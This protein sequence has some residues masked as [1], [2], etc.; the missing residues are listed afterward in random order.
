MRSRKEKRKFTKG[1][2]RKGKKGKKVKSETVVS[3]NS[4]IMEICVDS[5]NHSTTKCKAKGS[6]PSKDGWMNNK[7]K[8]NINSQNCSYSS[9]L[10]SQVF[11]SPQQTPFHSLVKTKIQNLNFD[12]C[13][14][15]GSCMSCTRWVECVDVMYMMWLCVGRAFTCCVARSIWMRI[16]EIIAVWSFGSFPPCF[17]WLMQFHLHF[18]AQTAVE[19]SV[20]LIF[21]PSLVSAN[22][23]V[24]S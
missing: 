13:R 24:S 17:L 8:N 9:F 18:S 22:E 23:K 2:R 11:A 12:F 16:E 6:N 15:W 20:L 3:E 14:K 19:T 4:L 5:G 10:P 1:K 7:Y 21:Q